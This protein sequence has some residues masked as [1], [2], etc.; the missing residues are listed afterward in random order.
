MIVIIDYG[1][2]NL[3]SIEQGLRHLGAE[4]LVSGNVEDIRSA[5]RLILPGV[6]AFGDAMKTLI[7]SGLVGVIRE[8]V[9]S[10][11]PILGICL[12]MQLLFERSE[13]FGE[14]AGLGVLKGSIGALNRGDMRVPNVG[15]RTLVPNSNNPFLADLDPST[16]VYF[17]HSFVVRPQDDSIVSATIPFNGE[18]AAI[19]VASDGVM[20]FQFHP[21]KSG[22]AGLSLLKRFLD[23]AA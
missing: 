15:W 14:H 12:G 23:R 17:V 22:P 1:R 7:A 19:A 16:M 18:N 3:F 10:G 11:I 21:E 20:G 5:D 9:R 8:Q 2:G 13:E 4:Y 6:G